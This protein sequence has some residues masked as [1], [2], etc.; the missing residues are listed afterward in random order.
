MGD[1]QDQAEEDRQAAALQVSVT[2]DESNRALGRG[3]GHARIL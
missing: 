1:G 3:D 2:D